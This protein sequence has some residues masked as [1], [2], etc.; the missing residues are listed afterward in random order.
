MTWS[1]SCVA[2]ICSA[3]GGEEGVVGHPERLARPEVAG[4]RERP[5]EPSVRVDDHQPV[6]EMIGDQYIRRQRIRPGTRR[7]MA[8]AAGRPEPG[9]G[10]RERAC[11]RPDQPECRDRRYQS[12]PVRAADQVGSPPDHGHGR[13]RYRYR[14][15][16]CHGEAAAARFVTKHGRA[17]QPG[18][19][20]SG[21]GPPVWPAQPAWPERR[22]PSGRGGAAAGQVDGPV[23]DER[24]CSGQPVR[25][26]ADHAR[27]A[28]AEIHLLDHVGRPGCGTAAK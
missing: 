1:S 5:A 26:A 9:G 17:G 13:A 16:P 8:A 7:Q 20:G 24:G 14:Q 10:G 25:Q 18:R 27:R 22:A 28:G 15:L 21:C 19:G 3:V 23:Q 11:V 4:A 6:V 2:M 12:S